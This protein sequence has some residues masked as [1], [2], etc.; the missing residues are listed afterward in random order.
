MEWYI[1]LACAVLG[2]ALLA[3]AAVLACKWGITFDRR[4]DFP[5]GGFPSDGSSWGSL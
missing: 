3:L 2:P 4:D 1:I 5:W